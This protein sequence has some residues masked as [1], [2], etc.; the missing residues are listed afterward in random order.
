MCNQ[1]PEVK[2]PV[3]FHIVRHVL[4]GR[5]S[6]NT[7]RVA[8]LAIAPCEILD[9]DGPDE[10]L[11]AQLATL[12]EA[13]L[14]FPGGDT[15]STPLAV[16]NVVV[17]DGTWRQAR[18]MF[19]KLPALSKMPRL[20]VPTPPVAPRRLRH[21]DDDSHMSTLEAMAQAIGY[22]GQAADAEA[23]HQLHRLWVERTLIGRGQRP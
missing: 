7:V 14:L 17:L 11:D 18:K 6:T 15:P 16:K 2:S 1:I 21:S 4:E 8:G 9:Y 10:A 23:L 22:F 20:S 12:S 13:C 3:R 19:R 5:K